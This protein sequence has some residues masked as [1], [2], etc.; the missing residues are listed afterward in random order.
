[1][2][3]NIMDSLQV[4]LDLFAKDAF[5]RQ[6]GIVLDELKTD[7]VKMHVTLRPEFN[8]FNG[9]PH[10]GIIYALADAAFSVIGNN[11]NNL[12]VALECSIN[13]HRSPDPGQVL[14]VEGRRVHETKHVG[15]YLFTL[16]TETAGKRD[17]VATMKST[18]Y[19][20]GKLI[21]PEK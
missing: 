6:F 1:M 2:K 19:R 7:S 17:L 13:Y 11:S 9:R 18:L 15:T 5:A 14:Y 8:N 4:V 3:G 10:G 21:Q 20:T 12:S 16:F